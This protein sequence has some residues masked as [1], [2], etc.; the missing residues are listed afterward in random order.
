MCTQKT[1]NRV[2]AIIII[3]VS[4]IIYLQRTIGNQAVQGVFDVPDAA[5]QDAAR[6]LVALPYITLCYRRTRRPPTWPY[7]LFCMI[8]GRSRSEALDV[9][10]LARVRAKLTEYDYA[11]L[12]STRC[13]KQTGALIDAEEK[14]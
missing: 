4:Q 5:V 9:L 1:I 8:H 7:N 2:R 11:V 3:V 10:S 13:F 14:V 6:R 12:F